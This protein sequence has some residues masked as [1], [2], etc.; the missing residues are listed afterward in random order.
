M[1]TGIWDFP[2]FAGRALAVVPMELAVIVARGEGLLD[3]RRVDELMVAEEADREA[4]VK[5]LR[6]PRRRCEGVGAED[7]RCR[8]RIGDVASG[9]LH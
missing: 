6:F 8:A 5:M 4:W 7:A 2:Y 9:T 1:N 3:S